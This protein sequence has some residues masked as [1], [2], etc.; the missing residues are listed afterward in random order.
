MLDRPPARRFYTY[1]RTPTPEKVDPLGPQ[2]LVTGRQAMSRPGRKTALAAA[3]SA[4][5]VVAIGC[6]RAPPP[7]ADEAAPGASEEPAR[8]V[9]SPTLPNELAPAAAPAGPAAPAPLGSATP[10]PWTGPYFIAT[11]VS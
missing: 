5:A 2:T 4:V 11:D 9:G 7:G 1:S 6:H 3:A 10:P 8:Q